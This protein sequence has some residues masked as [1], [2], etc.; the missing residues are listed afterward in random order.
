MPKL[1][2]VGRVISDTRLKLQQERLP[3]VQN[4]DSVVV[5]Q[6]TYLVFSLPRERAP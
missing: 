5:A 2:E 3:H 6:P 4:R 1:Y